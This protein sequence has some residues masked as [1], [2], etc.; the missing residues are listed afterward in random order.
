MSSKNRPLYYLVSTAGIPNL[1][2]EL[3]AAT[4]LRYLAETAP[5]ADVV[6][7]CVDPAGVVA[8]LGGVHPRLRTMSV[9]WQICFRN[10]S[11]GVR[12]QGIAESL[13]A[14]PSLAGDLREGV[15]LLRRADVVHLTGGGFLNGIWPAFV[16][17]LA[18]I[19]TATEHS[20]GVSA[21]TGV[22]LYPAIAGAGDLVVDLAS[23]FSVADVRD[24]AS[25][26]LLGEHGRYSC[27]DVFLSPG[28]WLGEPRGET[29]EVMVSIQSTRP[30]STL[31]P[32]ASALEGE[33]RL[34]REEQ[35]RA[36]RSDQGMGMLV[37]FFAKTLAEWG[38]R[39]IGLIECWPDV[40]R[41]ALDLAGSLAPNVRRYTLD[42][43]LRDGFPA[44]PGQTWLST[45][46]HPHLFAAA[47]GASGVAVNLMK[48][49]YDTKHRS[50]IEQG[51]SWSLAHYRPF[52]RRQEIPERPTS[53]GFTKESLAVLRARK[54]LV[55]EQI[56]G[57]R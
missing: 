40:D 2:D 29:P 5:D 57:G 38:V 26:G 1:G 21:V 14:D 32:P 23:R 12:T 48:G 10:W 16:G 36:V 6:L 39:D 56:Y 13:V 31:F 24:E 11:E 45:R 42:E 34:S 8:M 49:Y 30:P 54:L 25:A 35:A 17:L 9:L 47:A 20:G 44:A 22:G 43:V 27:D 51:S 15:E 41:R 55:A 50:L 53:G 3:I 28:A 18:G 19:A 33:A 37:G 46:F 52:S 4:W 7:D